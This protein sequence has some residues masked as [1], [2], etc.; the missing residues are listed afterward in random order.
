MAA[1]AVVV[2]RMSSSRRAGDQQLP[3]VALSK[4]NFECFVRELLLVRQYRVE[5]YCS[6]GKASWT[7]AYKVSCT[8]GGGK[9]QVNIITV[10]NLNDFMEKHLTKMPVLTEL[11][12]MRC[13]YCHSPGISR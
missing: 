7:L 2:V 3:S 6:K 10:L 9:L 1:I 11:Q 13:P 8:A 5:V 4:M 12:C